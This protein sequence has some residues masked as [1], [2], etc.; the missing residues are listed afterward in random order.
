MMLRTSV[1]VVLIVPVIMIAACHWT[2]A[3]LLMIPWLYF[4]LLILLLFFIVMLRGC[5]QHRAC[6]VLQLRGKVCECMLPWLLLM[7]L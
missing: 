2:D 6:V 5:Q 1:A 7:L 4:H 3:S